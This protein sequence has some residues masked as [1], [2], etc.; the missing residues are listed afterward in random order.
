VRN[1]LW[2][3]AQQLEK[4]HPPDQ[5]S[6]ATAANAD[7]NVAVSLDSAYVRATAGCPNRHL[8]VITGQVE[9]Q[10]QPSRCFALVSA[11]TSNQPAMVGM[12]QPP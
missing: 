9:T 4:A 6:K 12:T 7:Q 1:R 5:E 3:V 11:V 2:A 8:E 10:G